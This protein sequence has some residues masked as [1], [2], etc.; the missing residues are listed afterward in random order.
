MTPA[1]ARIVDLR[2]EPVNL[3]LDRVE[4]GLGVRLDRAT[5]IRKRRS[6]GGRT[7][8]GTWVRIERRG[9]ERIG[10]QG[11]NGTEAAAVLDGVVMP[12]WYRGL[13]WRDESE[14]AM[15]RADELELVSAPPIGKG[16]LVFRDP[17][18]PEAWWAALNSSS[19]RS[20][21]TAPRASPP[22]TPS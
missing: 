3:V 5:V 9:F 20:P 7:D 22:R 8:R 12:Q 16:A 21:P 1:A 13:A 18:L 15:W 14:P 19:T 4:Q 11:W 10:V 17:D 2:K 6:L